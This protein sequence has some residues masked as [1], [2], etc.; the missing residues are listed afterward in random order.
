MPHGLSAQTPHGFP[1]GAGNE[2]DGIKARWDRGLWTLRGVQVDDK[3]WGGAF[4]AHPASPASASPRRSN[5]TAP[6]PK[7]GGGVCGGSGRL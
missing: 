1:V 4:V 2:V 6:D 5:E 3:L 7:T